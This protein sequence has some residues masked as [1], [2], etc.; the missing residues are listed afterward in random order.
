[1]LL[2]FPGGVLRWWRSDDAPALARHADNRKVWANLRDR[3]PSPYTIEDA[4]AWVRHCTRE[5]PATNFVIDIGGEAVGGI[6][7]VLRSD[8]ERVDAEIGY[9]LGEAYW[10]RGVATGAVQAFAPWALQ[11][12]HLARLHALV[13]DFNAASA[14]VLEK[15]GF[16]FEGR[17]RHSAFKDG[18]LIDQ[19][20]YA[21][22]WEGWQP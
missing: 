12:F 16:T 11:R 14:R 21:R 9:W 13:F 22:V 7:L 18:R 15:A 5:V 6:G 8:V 19:L 17:L 20:L 1:M 3:F 4:D 2:P 10:N